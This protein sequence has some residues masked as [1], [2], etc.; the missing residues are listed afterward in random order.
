MS[1]EWLVDVALSGD[2]L[3]KSREDVLGRFVEPAFIAML[4]SVRPQGQ[5]GLSVDIDDLTLGLKEI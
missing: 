5:G 4:A 2:D 3:N 1:K